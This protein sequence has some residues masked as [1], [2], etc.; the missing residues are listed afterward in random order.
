MKINSCGAKWVTVSIKLKKFLK[1]ALPIVV[2]GFVIFVLSKM[3]K[4]VQVS[5]VVSAIKNFSGITLANAIG[6][7][8]FGYVWL[9]GY[10]YL[11]LRYLKRPVPWGRL[12]FTSLSAFALQR[13][14][15]PAPITGGAIRYRYYKKYGFSAADAAIITTLC[16]FFFT[17]GII[18]TAGLALLLD[19]QGLGRIIGAP[20]WLLRIAGAAILLGLSGFLIW[21][22]FRNHPIKIRSWQA[23]PPSL[24]LSAT[25]VVFGV[26][27]ISIVAGVLYVLLPAQVELSYPAFVGIYVLAMLAGALSHVPGGIGVFETILLLFIP[28]VDK[29]A[30][31][32]AMLAFRGVY[33][34]LPLLT[35]ALVDAIYELAVRL[36]R[37]TAE[38]R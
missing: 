24:G 1:R 20:N 15:G 8:A 25:Q 23:P 35:M 28:G 31:L 36:Q 33:Y 18:F 3:L 14:V 6:L 22:H 32:A 17:L 26:V 19:P 2:I 37:A 10:D 7:A 11:A 21:S 4:D 5:D 12:V 38:G 34:L 27:D 30:L 9:I 13:N 16:G 29:G